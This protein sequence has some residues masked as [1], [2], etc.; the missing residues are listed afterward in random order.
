MGDINTRC[1]FGPVKLQVFRA[2]CS[3][4]E[5]SHDFGGSD[6]D[7]PLHT[8]FGVKGTEKQLQDINVQPS[9]CC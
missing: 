5:Q 8:R 6:L 7:I 4:T 2:G 1:E 9:T 3:G